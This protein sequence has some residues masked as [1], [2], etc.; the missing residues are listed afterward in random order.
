VQD[1]A[2]FEQICSIRGITSES[3]C[4]ALHCTALHCTALHCTALS[5]C[6]APE[7]QE[8]A[9]C[10]LI[11]LCLNLG[12]I[13]VMTRAAAGGGWR[14]HSHWTRDWHSDGRGWRPHC[15]ALGPTARV[16][17]TLYSTWAYGP[18]AIQKIL[19]LGG[20]ANCPA[21]RLPSFGP[22][23]LTQANGPWGS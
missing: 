13:S 23:A 21:G 9:R 7:C 17:Y 19:P 20:G 2:D 14:P 22:T 11:L 5:K 3:H 15:I 6:P 1:R 8:W 10:K 16:L 4:T 12:Y 18:H